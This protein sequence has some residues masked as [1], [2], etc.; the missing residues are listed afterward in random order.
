M[1]RHGRTRG[2]EEKRYVGLV[3]ESLSEAGRVQL[4]TSP[5]R[6]LL[7]KKSNIT[8]DATD[9]LLFTSTLK[10]TQETADILFP[11]IY[12]EQIAELNET[13]FGKF[14][15]KNANELS[16]IPEYQAWIDSMGSLPFPGGESREEVGHRVENAFDYIICSLRCARRN[17]AVIVTHGGIIMQFMSD[18]TAD[19]KD[20]Y[21]FMTRNGFGYRITIDDALWSKGN[22]KIETYTVL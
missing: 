9:F 10:R 3:D 18:Y 5:L 4:E 21:S 8:K 11:G 2:N 20:Y 14:E 17:K 16:Q 12:P 13:D 15:Y 7:A 19:D 6:S 22:R 1:I